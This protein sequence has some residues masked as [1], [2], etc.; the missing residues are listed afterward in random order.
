MARIARCHI[1]DAYL[2]VIRDAKLHKQIRFTCWGCSDDY[3][4]ERPPL[5]KEGSAV[6]DLRKIFGMFK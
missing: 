3:V 2:G 1:C 4:P 6:D 5:S